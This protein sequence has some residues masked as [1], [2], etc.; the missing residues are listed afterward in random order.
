MTGTRPWNAVFSV[1]T[2]SFYNHVFIDWHAYRLAGVL[3][4]LG[5]FGF[6]AMIINRKVYLGS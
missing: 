2:K 1:K 6:E 5:G 3:E 4:A